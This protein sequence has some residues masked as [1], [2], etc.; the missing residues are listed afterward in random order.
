MDPISTIALLA[1]HTAQIE[2]IHFGYSHWRDIQRVSEVNSG[3]LPLLHTLK[4]DAVKESHLDS[5]NTMTP[6]TLS[7]F[8]NAVNLKGLVLSSE[9]S[10]FLNHFVFPNLTTLELSA[11]PAGEGLHALH[12]LDFL[13]ASPMLR[14][15]YMEVVANILFKGVP[16]QRVVVLPNVKSFTLVVND[17][18]SGYGLATSIS[19]PSARQTSL[20]HQRKAY[21]ASSDKIFPP[22]FSWYAIVSQYAGCVIEE[23]ALEIKHANDPIIA[24]LLTSRSADAAVLSLHFQATASYD[25]E[26]ETRIPF[27][28]LDFQVF[29]EASRTILT[30]PFLENVKRLHISHR[31]IVPRDR[32]LPSF[33]TK[34]E[35]LFHSVGPLEELTIHRC[36][37]RL[38]FN[39]F[40]NPQ[41]FY[42]AKLDGFPQTRKLTISH[43]LN[44]ET[45]MVELARRRHMLGK[46]F[47]LVTVRMCGL[48]TVMAE[49]LRPFVG[50]AECY[51]EVRPDDNC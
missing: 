50:A 8:P 45:C 26:N 49:R 39:P 5:P 34:V 7:I 6:P 14:V 31:I 27:E 19:C 22:P 32:E 18:R 23:V 51:E 10:P 24:C 21:N 17:G 42:D 9:G 40:L 15:V 1:P 3:P 4:I 38:Y 11:T 20:V 41:W 35:R 2:Y 43:P 44:D 12:L 28:E 13:E 16:L 33:S 25:G 48:P 46:P 47:E 29:S 36:D 30:H 37:L